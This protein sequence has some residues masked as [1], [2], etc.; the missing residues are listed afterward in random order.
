MTLKALVTTI[1]LG[2]SSVAVA[3]P[4][5]RDHRD[6]SF[7]YNDSYRDR[8]ERFGGDRGNGRWIRRQV[9]VTLADNITLGN[10][11]RRATFV[12]LDQRFGSIRKLRFDA[13]IGRTFIDSL[14]LQMAD[15]RTQT[16]DVRRMLSQR[17]ETFTIDIGSHV[18]GVFIHG[19]SMRGR[20]S[21]DII[22]LR[23]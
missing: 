14:T 18:T 5:V 3:D 19:S 2:I 7:T 21:I 16:I 15:G 23:R 9:A 11:F 20:G 6:D 4:M 22:G 10:R 17:A 12:S 13:E 8:D 1:V